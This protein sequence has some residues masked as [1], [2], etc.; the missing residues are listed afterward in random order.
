MED[1]KRHFYQVWKDPTLLHH[2]TEI[3]VWPQNTSWSE[4]QQKGFEFLDTFHEESRWDKRKIIAAEHRFVVPFGE[5]TL[6]G[7]VDCIEIAG[8]GSKKELR[9]IDYKTSSYR[10]TQLELRFNIQ[11]T[12][13]MYASTLPEFWEP[14][15]PTGQ[16]YEEYRS[17]PRKGLWYAI[18][19]NK[20][21]DVG[22]REDVDFM[23][24]ARVIKEIE[25]AEQADVHV[26]DISGRSCMW[27]AYTHLCATTIPVRD[28]VLE[29]RNARIA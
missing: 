10:P 24:L 16:M 26:P 27:C 1:A 28:V 20:I 15:D 7:F 25:H 17:Y 2:P 19:Q 4:L 8:A 23:R 6:K 21:L 13:Y 29:V 22:P 3:G 12:I 11:F 14:L 5:H 18:W 9:I